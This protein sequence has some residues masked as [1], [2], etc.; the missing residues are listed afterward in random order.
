MNIS[1]VIP[2]LG[3]PE[4][5]ETIASL[6]MSSIIPSEILLCIP[7]S[8][9]LLF[10]ASLQQNIRVVKT[11]K[12]GQVYQR[13]TGFLLAKGDFV[14]QLDDD[15]IL[16][17]DTLEKLALCLEGLDNKSSV[18]SSPHDKETG[19]SLYQN[20]SNSLLWS[21]AYWIMNGK[22]GFQPGVISLSGVNFNLMF[23]PS[24]NSINE[25]EWLPGGC[26]LHR[27]DNLITSDYY[28]L[29]GKAYTEDLIHS[30][31]LRKN[32]IS[33][34]VFEEAIS[35]TDC[36]YGVNTIYDFLNQYEAAKYAAI[37]A[38]KKLIRIK[39]YYFFNF[40]YWMIKKIKR[41]IFNPAK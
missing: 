22:K 29:K 10:D 1:V 27:K 23:Q 30:I 39:I 3:G 37:I 5:E 15:V 4:L 28:P 7:S 8:Y 18:S 2:T 6:Q 14:L 36:P 16:K 19:L 33:L 31:L 40:L 34:Y 20:N 11:D 38:N 9:E 26:L 21:L 17:K 32:G 13:I 41:S 12:K 35:Y 24:K 25:S